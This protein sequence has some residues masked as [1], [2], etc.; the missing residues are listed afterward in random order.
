MRIY[1]TGG[2]GFIGTHLIDRIAGEVPSPEIR[3]LDIARPRVALHQRFWQCGD[4]LLRKELQGSPPQFCSHSRGA[5][6]GSN[7]HGR[8]QH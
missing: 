5:S 6:G 8:K 2:S 4:I 7:R 1:V 3:N